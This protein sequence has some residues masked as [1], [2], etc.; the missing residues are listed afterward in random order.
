MSDHREDSVSDVSCADVTLFKNGTETVPP[1][2]E[3]GSQ[4][5][6]TH[7]TSSSARLPPEQLEPANNQ[8][9]EPVL[10]SN[11]STE[12][13]SQSRP[14]TYHD[15]GM[16]MDGIPPQFLMQM[17]EMMQRMSER[18]CAPPTES[19]IRIKDIYLPSFDPDTHVG[20]R[21]WCQHID[22]AIEAYKLS[23][24]DVRMKVCSLLKGRAKMWVDDWMVNSSTWEELRKN[25]ITTFEPENRY[26]RDIAMFREHVYDSSKDIAEFL[27]RA[28]ILWRRVTKDKLGDE[29]AVE[30]VIGCVNDERLRIELLNARATT[31]PELISVATSIRKKRSHPS[32]NSTMPN[33]RSRF[34][35]SQPSTS[36]CRICKKTNHSTNDC[37]FKPPEAKPETGNKDPKAQTIPTCTYCKKPGHSYETCFKRERSLTSNVNYV[38]SNKLAPIFI[39]IGGKTLQA[40]F[41]SGAECSIMRE[42]VAMVLP[43]QRSSAVNY[44][45]GIGQFPALSLTKLTTICVIDTI[46]IELEFHVLPDYEMSTDILVGMNLIHDTNLN[47]II[48]P[49]GTKLVHNT[50]INLVCTNS[51][52]FNHLDCDLTSEDEIS[53]LRGLLNKYEHL[54]IR[55]YPKTRVNTG[56]LEIRLKNPDK[57]VERRP[58]R[59]S[60]LEREKV[61]TIIQELLE[62][63]IIRESKSPYSS[64]IILVKKKNGDDRLCVDFR[65]LNSNTLRDHYPLPLI[66]DQIDQLANGHFYTSLDMAA[67]FHQ[68]PIAETSIEKTAFV[69]PD[70]LYEYLT[71]PFGLSNACSVY[72]RC[73]NRAL[74]SLLGTAAQVYVD[75]VLSKCTDFPEGISHLERILI[76]LQEAG[77]SINAD[78]CSFFKR[79]IEYLGNIVSDGQVRPSPRKVEALVKAPVP[80]TVK[81]VRQ[82]N[83]LAGYFRKYIPDFSRIMLPLYEL[84]KQGAKWTW[85]DNHEKAR[86]TIIEYLTSTPVLTLFQ[87]DAPIQLYTDASSLGYGAVLVQVI[88]GRQHA[89]AF[90]SMRTTEAESRYH[91]Y[92]LETLAVVRAIKHFRQYLYG[93][94]F[95]VITD[96]NALKASKHKKD[97]L[98]RIHRWWAFL[99][100][101]DFEIEYRKG[102]RLQHA[103]FFSRNPTEFAVNVMT[104]DMNWLKIEQR[105]DDQ[106]RP[107]MD[108]LS[109]GNSVEGYVLEDN[110][111]K[112]QVN[113]PVFGQQ[114]STVVPKAFQWSIINSFHTVLKHPGWEKTLQKI[115][116]TYWF[117]KMSSTIRRFVDNCVI[118]RTSKGR[119]GAIQAQLHPIEKPSAAFQ[120][121]HMDITGKLGTPDDQQYVI[122]TIDAF[123]KYVLFYFSSNKNPHSTLAALKRTVHLFG[124]PIQ[125]IVDG[126]REFLGEFKDYCDHAGINIHAIAPGVSRA[127]G[128]VER[129]VATLKNAL[130]M[131]KNYETEQWHTTLEELQL[132]MNCTTHRVTG[133]AP[134]TLI[135]QRK[136]CVPSE[137]LSI[138]NI[139]TETVDIEALSQQVLQKMSRSSEQDRQRFNQHKAKI[140]HFQI[141]DYVLIKNN[142]RNQTSLDLKFSEPYE[143]SRVLENDRYLV[144]KVVGRGRPR[145]VAHDQLRRAPQPGE[146]LTVSAGNGSPGHQESAAFEPIPST[147][148]DPENHELQGENNSPE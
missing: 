108:S 87:E 71:M 103:D 116:E 32:S 101:Y 97:L 148:R 129:V 30:A 58:Y 146:Q 93:R 80:K 61:R 45:K 60:P 41:D 88:N 62:H 105:R 130:V 133:V 67:G 135:T 35:D 132:A 145:K 136:H 38:G 36:S 40:V 109:G 19:K 56:E 23:D 94:K 20:V 75:D 110:V 8:R 54:F 73:I 86:N 26:S 52:I 121:I 76:A 49:H 10:V 128:Q 113:D 138:V 51:P 4:E 47:V 84:T 44:L 68:I 78:K 95:T 106:L 43:G 143:V 12:A 55:G 90:M 141:G 37:R 2:S 139:D 66:S 131:I 39:K 119:S 16:R 112:K 25:L 79:S 24:F 53:Q 70:G 57:F 77:F 115:R 34:A 9:R 31:V 111:L 65:E 13:I 22:Q 59:L 127:N 96:C 14:H 17:M 102:E 82:F 85:T 125:I 29:H 72:Q 6:S 144:K 28:W 64:P 147:S 33:K 126:G 63:N 15:Q 83:G 117:D 5:I 50:I 3:V 118:C 74:T 27:S 123:S 92:E 21:E 100:N 134:L 89:V 1:S 114:L 142:P 120:V 140:H 122:V 107:I 46:N 137:L 42:S 98:P 7:T 48:T 99:Q 81:Q 18:L 91:S 69:T 104:R 11:A 124:A